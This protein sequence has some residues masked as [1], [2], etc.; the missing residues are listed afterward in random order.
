[1]DFIPINKNNANQSNI[2]SVNEIQKQLK[3]EKEKNLKLTEEVNQLKIELQLEREKNN[4]MVKEKNE[5][6]N[7]T[8][9]TIAELNDKIKTLELD[10]KNKIREIEILKKDSINLNDKKTL[11]LN[12]NEDYIAIAF[13]SIDN[14]FIYP[15]PCKLTDKFI[16]LEEKL[17]EYYPQFEE[18]PEY[19]VNGNKIYRYKSLKDNGI[20]CHD[21]ILVKGLE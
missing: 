10:L 20:K 12:Q 17:F 6:K 11:N 1:M 15:L 13:T 5:L 18:N 19:T 3:D 4:R 9:K 21:I 2:N 14:K 7:L 16:K 8:D